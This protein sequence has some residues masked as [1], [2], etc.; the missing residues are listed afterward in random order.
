[1]LLPASAGAA[2]AAVAVIRDAGW[3]PA[4]AVGEG[5]GEF[6]VLLSVA[7][8]LEDHP[9]VAVVGIG[10]RNGIVSD[11]AERALRYVAFR[12]VPV[13]MLADGGLPKPDPEGIFL[14][15][16]NLTVSEVS[17]VLRRCLDRYGPLPAAA[18]PAHPSSREV[19]ALRA[20]LQPYRKALAMAAAS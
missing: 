13:V 7:R 16:R 10:G 11:G 17:S 4:T 6:E 2:D 12:G 1:M 15:G 18:D 14:S 9:R 5:A 20:D 8:L 19:A 3:S